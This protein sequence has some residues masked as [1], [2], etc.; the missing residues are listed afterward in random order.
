M[1]AAQAGPAMAAL[2]LVAPGQAEAGQPSPEAA[3]ITP[4]SAREVSGAIAVD[5]HQRRAKLNGP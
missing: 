1:P 5:L 3:R 4:E 2:P